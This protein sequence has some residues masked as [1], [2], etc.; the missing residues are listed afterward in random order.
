MATASAMCILLSV[1]VVA[2]ANLQGL[3]FHPHQ[4]CLVSGLQ[5]Q[6]LQT[7]LVLLPASFNSW[8]EISLSRTA[9]Q[10]RRQASHTPS[11]AHCTLALSRSLCNLWTSRSHAPTAVFNTECVG[12]YATCLPVQLA[13]SHCR[14]WRVAPGQIASMEPGLAASA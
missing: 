11:T 4:E 6:T 13:S 14:H 10:A 3:G 8:H 2:C 1:M 7:A 12:V 5:Q 9:F